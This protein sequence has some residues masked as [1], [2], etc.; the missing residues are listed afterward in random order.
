[1]EIVKYRMT[2]RQST[3]FMVKEKYP[4]LDFSNINF[5]DM[6]GHDSTDLPRPVQAA[7]IQPAE[8]G[9]TQ[10]VEEVIEAEGVQAEIVE[11]ENNAENAV[12]VPFD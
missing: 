4:D 1:M 7:P 8:E 5:L 6:K 9:G 10:I 11:G 3:L 2:F 12:L